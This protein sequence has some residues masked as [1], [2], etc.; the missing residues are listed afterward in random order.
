M[1]PKVQSYI[2]YDKDRGLHVNVYATKDGA[3]CPYYILD[4]KIAKQ[5]AAYASMRRDLQDCMESVEY[6]KEIN[7]DPIIPKMV[8]T[9]LL[10]AAI[11]LYA[12]CFTQG[13]GRGTS[14]ERKEVFKGEREEHLKFHD[15]TMDIRNSYLAHAGN[16]AHESRAMVLVLN[17]D[18]D[19]KRIEKMV[20]AGMDLQDDD[21]NLGNYL[22]LFNAVQNHVNEKIEKVATK[23]HGENKSLNIKEVYKHSTLPGGDKLIPFPI[24]QL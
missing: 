16:S 10:F 8:K 22:N 20:Y 3:I 7:D 21:S 24:Q 9:S 13:E 17:P 5:A 11:V 18:H 15:Q 2:Y 19:N 1:E 12:K 6:L 14:L 23:L 4:S